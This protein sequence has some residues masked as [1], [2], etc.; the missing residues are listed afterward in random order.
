M[1]EK[2][3]EVGDEVVVR[4]EVVWVDEDGV[5]RVRF[6]R[7][8]MPIRISATVFDSV[9]KPPKPTKAKVRVKPVKGLL[10]D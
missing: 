8:Q 10:P 9:S 2:K 1:A 6:P 4:G 7:S 5:P 3:I